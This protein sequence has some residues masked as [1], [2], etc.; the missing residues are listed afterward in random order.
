MA[1]ADGLRRWLP[2][3]VAYAIVL[4][5]VIVAIYKARDWSMEE[6]ATPESQAKW[7]TWRDDVRQQQGQPGP[8][9]RR[10]PKSSEPPALVMMRDHFAV[11]LFGAVLFSTM[12]YWVLAWFVMG[13]MMPSESATA[14]K[15]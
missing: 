11:S 6:L 9:E 2:W 12:L 4:I 5:A 3:L 7:Q 1:E 10:V 8:V 14:I 13:V 15:L